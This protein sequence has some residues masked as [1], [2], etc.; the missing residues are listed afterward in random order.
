MSFYNQIEPFIEFVHSIRK[1]ENYLTFDMVFPVKW[2]LPKSIIDE[3]QVVGFE[4][5]DSNYKG[6]SFVTPITD[7]DIST[8]LTKVAKIIRLNKE[9]EL[10]D[11]LFKETV[12]QLKATFEKTDLDKLQNLYF[13]FESENKL[14][15]IDDKIDLDEQYENEPINVKLA[16]PGDTKRPKKSGNRQRTDGATNKENQ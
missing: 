1:L 6:V 14:D 15:I 8:T 11:R 3:N 2:S 13:D 12:E 4:A 5:K 16:E 9:R 7:H 10:K